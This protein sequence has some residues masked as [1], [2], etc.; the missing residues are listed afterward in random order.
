[1]SK[2]KLFLECKD[3]LQTQKCKNYKSAGWC[4]IDGIKEMCMLTCEVC[5]KYAKFIF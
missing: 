5:G 1:M 2:I 3:A 4:N